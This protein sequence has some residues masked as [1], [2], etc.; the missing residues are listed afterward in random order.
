MLGFIYCRLVFRAGL[1]FREYGL[2]LRDKVV[3]SFGRWG[4]VLGI[5]ILDLKLRA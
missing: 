1:G 2:G 5:I 4:R 3:V